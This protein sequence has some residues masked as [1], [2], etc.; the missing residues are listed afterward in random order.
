MTEA[1]LE[2]AE[3][4][5]SDALLG[6]A[7]VIVAERA[8]HGGARLRII[9]KQERQID[10]AELRHAVGE[11]AR[12][13]VAERHFAG[14]DQRKDVL[15]LVAVVH[16]VPDVIDGHAITKPVQQFVADEFERLAEACGG[17]AVAGHADPERF[18][19][20]G[21]SIPVVSGLC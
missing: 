14:L 12:R 8:V 4:A 2:P 7:N 15:G 16:D 10:K 3:D 13:L 11:I 1:V 21:V 18:R 6:L 19:H 9:G 17:R 5:V 20:A